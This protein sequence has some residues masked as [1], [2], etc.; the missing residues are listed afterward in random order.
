MTDVLETALGLSTRPS[1]SASDRGRRFFLVMSFCLLALLFVAFARTFFLRSLFDTP[2]ITLYIYVHGIVLT[3]WFVLFCVQSSLVAAH[4]TDLHRRLG[5]F[6]VGLAVL[7]VVSSL[8]VNLH[9]PSGQLARSSD[10]AL[11]GSHLFGNFATL[12]VF[13]VLIASAVNLRHRPDAHKRLMLLSSI[14]LASGPVTT[15]FTALLGVPNVLDLPFFV[16]VLVLYDLYSLKRVHPVTAN[17]GLLMFG[18][19]LF[20][21]ILLATASGAAFVEMLRHW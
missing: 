5:V 8:L 9:Y 16:V 21:K 12:V 11:V 18:A 6:G 13:P 15:R 10:P 19:L 17:G 7:V 4:R 3:T 2:P 14:A 20:S 1:Q